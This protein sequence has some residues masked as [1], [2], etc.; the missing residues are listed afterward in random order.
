M[1]FL[2]LR[3]HNICDLDDVANSSLLSICHM[4]LIELHGFLKIY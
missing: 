4:D 1:Q 3:L 2:V